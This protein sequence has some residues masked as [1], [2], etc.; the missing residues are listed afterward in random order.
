MVN[1]QPRL[2]KK[3]KKINTANEVKKKS[4]WISNFTLKNEYPKKKKKTE[5][6]Y[7]FEFEIGADYWVSAG[8][9]ALRVSIG[10][11]HTDR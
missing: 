7:G 8:N 6:E 5:F 9:F 1:T 10:L 2:K 4:E 3:K 11:G